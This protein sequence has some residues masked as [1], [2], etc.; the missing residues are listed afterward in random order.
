MKVHWLEVSAGFASRISRQIDQPGHADTLAI[1][2]GVL[3]VVVMSSAS[4]RLKSAISECR[5]SVR[6][7]AQMCIGH[8]SAHG[9]NAA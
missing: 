6:T 7:P 2:L 4:L 3:G 5:A 1:L 8:H 9:L